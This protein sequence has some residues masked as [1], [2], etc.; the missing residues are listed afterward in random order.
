M[1]T[2]D[3]RSGGEQLFSSTWLWTWDGVCFGFRRKDSLFTWDGFE[4]GR[5][6]GIE[7]YGPDGR[8]LGEVRK[9]DDGDRLIT[10]CYKKSNWKDAFVPATERG[11]RRVPNRA[12]ESL[13]CGFEHFPS[14]KTLKG[15]LAELK[16]G[17]RG[18][19][20]AG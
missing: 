10:S 19:A 9:A 7:I 1:S 8:Y 17:L 3:T 18:F 14:A 16:V 5:F 11:H 12:E 15:M 13:Y 4:V 6:S 2:Q 20:N